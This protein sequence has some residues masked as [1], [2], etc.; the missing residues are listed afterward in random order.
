[1]E[2]SLYQVLAIRLCVKNSDL[3]SMVMNARNNPCVEVTRRTS[4]GFPK[5]SDR[6]NLSKP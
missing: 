2:L 4:A 3:I 5:K 1:M 6:T